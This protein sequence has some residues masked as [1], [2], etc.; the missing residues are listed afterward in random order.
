MIT[1]TEKRLKEFEAQVGSLIDR[2]NKVENEHEA[3]NISVRQDETE[4]DYHYIKGTVESAFS[5]DQIWKRDTLSMI[6]EI[7]KKLEGTLGIASQDGDTLHAFLEEYDKDKVA[8]KS[9]M[10]IIHRL[11]KT[12]I[13]NEPI[14]KT[15]VENCKKYDEQFFRL[16]SMSKAH[17]ENIDKLKETSKSTYEIASSHSESISALR[18]E[19]TEQNDK[20]MMILSNNRRETFAK[21]D[22]LS[23]KESPH[24]DQQI[25]DIKKDLAPLLAFV[26]TSSTTV[27]PAQDQMQDKIKTMEKSIAQV[28]ELLKK[29]QDR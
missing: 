3:F 1:L 2:I 23:K 10:D 11:E 25:A 14:L 28:Y 21:I 8:F 5:K 19:L 7:R 22:E 27:N 12:Q 9:A 26:H 13:L 18:K 6:N 24:Y 15:F 16:F 4:R 17:L 20:L 29:Y